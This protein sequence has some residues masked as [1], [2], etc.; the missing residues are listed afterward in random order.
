VSS[1]LFFRDVARR[2]GQ[3]G[4]IAPS[5]SELARLMVESAGLRPDHVIVELGAG[6]GSITRSIREAQPEAPLLA[7]EP[8]AELAAHLRQAFPGVEVTEKLAHQLP[9][10]LAAWGHPAVDRVISGLPWTI[11]SRE[12]Q[13]TI[14]SSV[15]GVMQP[16]AKLVTFTYVH[17][18]VLPGASALAELLSGWFGKVEKTRVAWKNLPPAFAYVASEPRKDRAL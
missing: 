18:Q 3:M 2:P 11:W 12:T 7:M 9:E 8:G 10:A 17:S 6:T 4:A 1:W 14:L 15:V 16:D 13:D 5:G